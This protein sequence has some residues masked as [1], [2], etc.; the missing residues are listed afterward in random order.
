MPDTPRVA[1][2]DRPAFKASDVCDLA[3]IQ[4]YVLRSWESEFP[5]LGLS[6]TPG[7]PRIYRRADVERVLRIRDLVFSEG[8]TLSGVRRR[9]DSEQP[10]P[11]D[12]VPTVAEPAATAVGFNDATRAQIVKLKQ[13]LRSLLDLLDGRDD[14]RFH[15]SAA[16]AI[17]KKARRQA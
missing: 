6:K 1:I 7:G 9:F 10:Q 17:R 2:P 12:Q 4:P 13:E 5:D 8:L 15:L 11:V 16:G 3:Q 14:A